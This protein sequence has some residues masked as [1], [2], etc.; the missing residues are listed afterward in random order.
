MQIYTPIHAISHEAKYLK[1]SSHEAIHVGEDV[2][3]WEPSY[4]PVQMQSSTA[5]LE[6]GTE[7]LQEVINKA[8]LCPS[9]CTTGYLPPETVVV[10]TGHMHH[11]VHSSN[12]HNRQT[13][14]GVQMTMDR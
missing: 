4:T 6:N 8:T 12:I 10:K 1:I 9:N 5:T 13:V 11:S 2:E 7:F 3:K 14:E